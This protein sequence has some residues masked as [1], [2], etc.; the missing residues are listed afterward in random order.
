MS[1]T[2]LWT[3]KPQWV[4]TPGKHT[5]K[6]K[7]HAGNTYFQ[8]SLSLFHL[9]LWQFNSFLLISLLFLFVPHNLVHIWRYSFVSDLPEESL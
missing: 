8:C 9:G 3:I 4:V 7:L 1:A 6:Q 2:G 5:N